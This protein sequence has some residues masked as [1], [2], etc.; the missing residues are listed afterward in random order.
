MHMTSVTNTV[1]GYIR[2]L[3]RR[4]ARFL[5]FTAVC[6][7][8]WMAVVAVDLM[9]GTDHT[10]SAPATT[11]TP[12]QG[13]VVAAPATQAPHDDGYSDGHLF[14]PD[15]MLDTSRV[16]DLRE[17]PESQCLRADG[18]TTPERACVAGMRVWRDELS[19][20][21]WNA[22]VGQGYIWDV[23]DVDS[24]WIPAEM[25]IL[26]QDDV[27]GINLGAALTPRLIG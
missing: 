18:V 8:L 22:L 3:A 14:N 19:P 13:P 11:T 9:V 12:A 23:D 6:M 2:K 24:L 25:V 4:V 21:Q 15:A 27:A 16:D 5:A 1:R 10:P 20:Q 7:G 17:T 26:D